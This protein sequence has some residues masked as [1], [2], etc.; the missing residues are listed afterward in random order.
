MKNRKGIIK[1]N[2]YRFQPVVVT[3]DHPETDVCIKQKDFDYN[4]IN[5]EVEFYIDKND[6]AVIITK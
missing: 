5:S 4:N 1:I 2:P 3:E 6:Y